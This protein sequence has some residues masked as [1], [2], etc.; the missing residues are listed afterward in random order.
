MIAM[1]GTPVTMTIRRR[2]Y[3]FADRLASPFSDARRRAFI[4][5]MLTGLIADGACPP[6]GKLSG[7]G[8]NLKPPL[9]TLTPTMA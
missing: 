7:V 8:I 5:D 6:H 3:S 4:V 2:L 9:A 1:A